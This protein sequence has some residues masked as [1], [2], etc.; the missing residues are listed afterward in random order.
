MVKQKRTVLLCSPFGSWL[1][2][3]VLGGHRHI[4]LNNA[5]LR[6]SV[7]SSPEIGQVVHIYV[8]PFAIQTQ[9]LQASMFGTTLA[10]RVPKGTLGRTMHC[11]IPATCG[12]HA[13]IMDIFALGT[14][15]HNFLL[16]PMEIMV[17]VN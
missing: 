3:L 6:H 16:A 10:A 1:G 11:I 4:Q 5:W 15:N 12:G 2:H 8:Y 14:V 17:Y 13:C 9:M 7:T